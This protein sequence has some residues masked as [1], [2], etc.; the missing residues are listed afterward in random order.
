MYHRI[1]LGTENPPRSVLSVR[2]MS[3]PSVKEENI[4][5]RA[6]NTATNHFSA[7][8]HNHQA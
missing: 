2:R 1:K 8:M 6:Q 5:T 3:L 7:Y 4:E